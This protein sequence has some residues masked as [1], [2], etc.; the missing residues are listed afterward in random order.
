[1]S[2]PPALPSKRVIRFFTALNVLVYRL[3]GGRLMNRFEGAPICLVTMT[4]RR[5][6]KRKTLALMY[7]AHGE[8]VLLVASL[9]GAPQHPAWYY[10]LKA[11]PQVE[12]QAG[13]VRRRMLARE[14]S[15]EE[16]RTLW[17]VAVAN[18]KSF[19]AYQER[20][21]REIPLF[22]CSPV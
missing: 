13:R 11:H 12:I 22:V 10:N 2:E 7:T 20:T 21:S 1:M 5:S 16:K 19:A 4:G 18:Y 17:P 15:S 8:D 3:T 6:G 9:G 14:A